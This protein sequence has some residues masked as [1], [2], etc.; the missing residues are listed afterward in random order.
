VET[1]TTTTSA[2][3]TQRGA[4]VPA[5]L[6]SG[7]VKWLPDRFLVGLYPPLHSPSVSPTKVLLWYLGSFRLPLLPC[8]SKLPVGSRSGHAGLP[9][10]GQ[11]F[12]PKPEQ[13]FPLL[14]FPA[15]WHRPWQRL[16]SLATLWGDELFLTT[17]SPTRFLWFLQRNWPFSVLYAVN[18]PA[19]AATV[20]AFYCPLT[21][22]R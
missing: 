8:S 13:H 3:C 14:M 11:I 5:P 15:H 21:Y 6:S 12:S 10:N 18:C 16:D 2:V 7:G 17:C 20:T 1:F 4:A 19:F 22:T 9:G